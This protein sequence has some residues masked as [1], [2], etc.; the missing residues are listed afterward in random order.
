MARDSNNLNRTGLRID[1]GK[2]S[3]AY[4]E[5]KTD[6]CIVAKCSCGAEWVHNEGETLERMESI[7]KSHEAYDRKAIPAIY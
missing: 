6:K 4:F 1:L 2:H 7:F 5:D 3:A